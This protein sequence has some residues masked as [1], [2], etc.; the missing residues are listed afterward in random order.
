[1]ENTLKLKAISG[2][3]RTML[4]GADAKSGSLVYTNK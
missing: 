3:G 1:M 2:Q 4:T